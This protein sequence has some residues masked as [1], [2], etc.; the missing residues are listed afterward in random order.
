MWTSTLMMH[1][2]LL[3]AA[4]L[5]KIVLLLNSSFLPIS[6]GQWVNSI[7]HHHKDYTVSFPFPIGSDKYCTG[8]NTCMYDLFVESKIETTV[9]NSVGFAILKIIPTTLISKFDPLG[10]CINIVSV[11]KVNYLRVHRG[12]E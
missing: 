10:F 1:R 9:S 2:P 4:S 3:T 11:V 7:R 6:H 5:F 8:I 12:G